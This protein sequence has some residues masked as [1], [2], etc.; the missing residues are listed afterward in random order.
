[1]SASLDTVHQLRSHIVRRLPTAKELAERRPLAVT[2]RDQRM[3]Y[4]IYTHGLLTADLIELAFF[5]GRQARHSPSS[6]CYERLRALWLWSHVDRI[7]LPVARALGGSRPY[8]YTLGRRGVPIV[9]AMLGSGAAPVQRRRLDRL[10]DIFVD[11]DL[12]VAAFWANLVALLRARP[13][14]LQRWVSER[15][16]RARPVRVQDPRT[17]RWLP[18]LPDAAFEVIYPNRS[19]QHALLEVDMGTLTLARFRR[20]LRAFELYRARQM[21]TPGA[22]TEFEVLVLTHSRPRLD[23]LWRA[24]RREVASQRWELYSFATFEILKSSAFPEADWITARNDLVPLLY[25][26]TPAAPPP[27]RAAESQPAK[28]R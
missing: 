5:P 4:A 19:V 8:L 14:R 2:H 7:E 13:A 17:Q 18:V 3:L 23:Q 21:A 20:K 10:D 16:L 9:G 15:A 12:K 1:M 28:P 11:H 25:E 26:D 24:T 22:A 27:D 6:C